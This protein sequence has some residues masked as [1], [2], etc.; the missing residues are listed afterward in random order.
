MAK[1]KRTLAQIREQK[2]QLTG[3]LEACLMELHRTAGMTPK[4]LVR[5]GKM[6]DVEAYKKL[7]SKCFQY[8]INGSG[9]TNQLI[10][11]VAKVKSMNDEL[12]KYI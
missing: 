2:K 5:D 7:Q 3:E 11:K 1:P 6:Q 10:K 12:L 9:S 8:W 4:K